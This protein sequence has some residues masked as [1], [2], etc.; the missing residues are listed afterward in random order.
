MKWI[1]V[2]AAMLTRTPIRIGTLLASQSCRAAAP[3]TSAHGEVFPG[4]AGSDTQQ[5]ISHRTERLHWLFTGASVGAAHTSSFEGSTQ[6]S[7]L[8]GGVSRCDQ[9]GQGH[10]H[11]RLA[12]RR[13]GTSRQLLAWTLLKQSAADASLHAYGTRTV[14]GRGESPSLLQA[15]LEVDPLSVLAHVTV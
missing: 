11:V 12:D 7:S 1:E 2:I 6:S 15:V 8:Y 5:S 14:D 10:N 13:E 4:L 9:R 3:V